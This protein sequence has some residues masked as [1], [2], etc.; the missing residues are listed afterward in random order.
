MSIQ[1]G[2]A[3]GRLARVAPRRP[4]RILMS[5]DAVGGVWRYGIDL[6]RSLA[7]RK[8][9]VAMVGFGPQ[10]S[11][12]QLAEAARARIPMTWEPL[13]L[14]WMPGGLAHI[15]QARAAVVRAANAFN[16]DLVH[17]NSLALA[18][19]ELAPLPT[20][21]VAHSCVPTWWRTVRGPGPDEFYRAH[22]RA[23]KAGLRIASVVITPSR[24]H[25][26]VLSA[27]YGP[28]PAV[29]VV[30]NASADPSRIRR[31]REPLV[32]AAGR[33][34]DEAKNARVLDAAAR[35]TAWPVV[36]AG[37]LQDP[38][39][40]R[41]TI[42]HARAVGPLDSAT[43]FEW[44]RRASIFAAPS[45]Y[46]PFGLAVLE[47]ARA[48]T[49]LVLADIPTFR[50]LWDGAAHFAPPRNAAAFANAINALVK[51]P[52][53]RRKLAMRARARAARFTHDRQA[54]A[55]LRVYEEAAG[56]DAGPLMRS[57]Y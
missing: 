6:A 19:E 17:L 2:A 7:E 45:L 15:G 16:A 42:V 27:V 55:M 25:A 13:P 24:S 39:G 38:A 53:L 43:T 30:Y 8:V 3:G 21:V 1:L 56:T 49:P 40:S 26:D 35:M 9:R 14:D 50:E 37:S 23:N 20:V 4:Q 44:M 32:F 12:A 51:D 33:W 36:M 46:E 57:A 5:V 34:W 22:A 48:S 28:H 47:A 31:R 29:R 18:G 52:G 41:Q 54:D 11:H 10:P